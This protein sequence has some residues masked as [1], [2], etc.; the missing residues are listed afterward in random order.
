MFHGS[1]ILTDPP[2][3]FQF[4]HVPT[5][6]FPVLRAH[7]FLINWFAIKIYLILSIDLFTLLV[8]LSQDVYWFM[9][10]AEDHEGL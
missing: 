2:C 1:K 7:I 5:C 8:I 4:I 9:Q 10:E 3:L 6:L